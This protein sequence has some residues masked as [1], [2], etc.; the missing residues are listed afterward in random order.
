MSAE[1]A[2][3]RRAKP[4]GWWGIALL[5]ATEASLLGAL[6]A[7]YFYL[8]FQ[9]ATWPPRGIEV[10][11]PLAPSVLTVVLVLS[12]IPM[13]MAARAARAGALGRAR[14]AIGFALL[15]QAAYLAIQLH[16]YVD[17]LGK[18]NPADSSYSSIYYTLLGAHHAH[19]AVGMLLSLGILIKLRRG[20]TNYRAVGVRA[21]A[22][23]WHFT[24]AVAVAVLLTQLSPRL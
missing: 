17:E 2:P 15:V 19:V 9:N 7:S 18:H 11:D 16:A 14:A 4:N 5:I 12:S 20:L 13:L 21:I 3:A 24:N 6:I 8:R 1:T 10:P 22:L 23:Y